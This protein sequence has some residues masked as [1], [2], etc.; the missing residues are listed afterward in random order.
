MNPHFTDR[1][2]PST[3]RWIVVVSMLGMAALGAQEI[4]AP[5]PLRAPSP[6]VY[7]EMPPA[8]KD[9]IIDNAEIFNPE[10][11]KELAGK[12]DR[13]LKSDD[14]HIYVATYTFVYGEEA[15]QRAWRLGRKWLE[16]KQG[17]VVV[18]DKGGGGTSPAIGL[19]WQQDDQRSLQ[20]RTI[21]GILEAASEAANTSASKKPT[22]QVTAAVDEIMAGFGRVRP[23]LEAGHQAARKRQ[24]TILGGVLG[25][26]FLSLAVLTVVRRFQTRAARR[27]GESYLFPHVEIAP[28]YDAP[29]GGGVV[30]Q[31]HY[32]NPN[33]PG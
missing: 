32:A 1:L 27:N 12:I 10:Q 16:G 23:I 2:T 20:D 11:H 15:R 30:V 17:A 26:M 31:M 29:F 13:F 7:E 5:D 18:F 22:E 4:V 3:A 19:I 8:P 25:A 21:Q 14:F 28:R 24:Y 33:P 6:S 9:G